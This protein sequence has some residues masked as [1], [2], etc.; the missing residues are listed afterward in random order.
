[1]VTVD[2]SS[3]PLGEPGAR[4]L[5]RMILKGMTC[6]V[7]MRDC[8]FAEDPT[9][10]NHSNPALNSPYTLDLSEPYQCAL[11]VEL[12]NMYCENP[13]CK[14][15]SI[16]HKLTLAGKESTYYFAVKN[17]EMVLRQNGY[18]WELPTAGLVKVHFSQ[19]V[20]IPVLED[21]IGPDAFKVLSMMVIHAKTD[22]D[23]KNWLHL[24]CMDAKFTTKQVRQIEKIYSLL[25]S[26]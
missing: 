25:S 24:L 11:L 26:V 13:N 15:E 21:A 18:Y 9:A 1:M 16:T 4:S 10:F 22:I 7:A 3:N 23:R 12:K 17:G 6:Y 2:L 5:F 14:I 20:S 19:K 8:T